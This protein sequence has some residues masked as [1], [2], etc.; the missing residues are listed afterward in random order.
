[1]SLKTLS[2]MTMF[3]FFV[4]TAIWYFKHN[5]PS[6]AL[7]NIYLFDIYYLYFQTNKQEKNTMIN[8]LK[9]CCK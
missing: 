5:I 6:L 4:L 2:T 1:M 9:I 8:K 7:E 3:Y